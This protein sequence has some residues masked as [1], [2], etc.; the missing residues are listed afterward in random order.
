MQ[1]LLQTFSSFHLAT[2]LSVVNQLSIIMLHSLLRRVN[3]T[4]QLRVIYSFP[5]SVFDDDDC[6]GEVNKGEE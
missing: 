3:P 2:L 4:W 6:K 1:V 5:R